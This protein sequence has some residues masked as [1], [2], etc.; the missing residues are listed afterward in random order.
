MNPKK[1]EKCVTCRTILKF[2]CA[3]QLKQRKSTCRAQKSPTN[4]QQHNMIS[5]DYCTEHDSNV[6]ASDNCCA[7]LRTLVGRLCAAKRE[8]TKEIL[9][10]NLSTF[11]DQVQRNKS[12]APATAE[13]RIVLP[14][15]H[16]SFF[17]ILC[18]RARALCVF[19]LLA[20]LS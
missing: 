2:R 17:L 18:M 6:T 3:K 13:L 4:C 19:V 16:S 7:K 11:N 1:K 8:M 14:I 9:I 20:R 15:G 5:T 10:H 12:N